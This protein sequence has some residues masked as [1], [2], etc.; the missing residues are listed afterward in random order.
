MNILFVGY[1]SIAKKHIIALKKIIKNP[2]IY[3][4]RHSLND[5]I[6]IDDIEINNIYSWEEIDQNIDCI[7]ITNPTSMHFDSIIK[8]VKYNC[9]IFIEKPVVHNLQNTNLIS[10]L[11]T[12]NNIINY[13]GCDLR[14]HPSL[15]FLKNYL[16]N[17][18]SIINEVNIYCGSFL[19][20]WRINVDYKKTYSSLPE[21]GGGVHL[22]L[23]HE[24]DYCNWIFG[25]PLYSSCKYSNKSSLNID[26]FDYANIIF[27]YETFTA[28]I[29]L[30]YYRIDTKRY[31]EILTAN[32]T[33]YLDLLTGTIKENDN[34]IYKINFNI[35]RLYYDQMCYFLD[36]VKQKKQSNNTFHDSIKILNQIIK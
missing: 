28:S 13:V 4:L 33:I 36:C 20:E 22:D 15:I 26:S 18:T 27:E 29:I 34:I 5:S 6:K 1:G 17:S 3:A 32:G 10:D 11:L 24:P 23:F 19:P 30:N 9:P 2:K 7:F 35:E 14:F 12:N 25:E 31:F 16:D 21:L 8:S